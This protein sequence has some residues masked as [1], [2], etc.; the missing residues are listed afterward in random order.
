MTRECPPS[1]I[2]RGGL[3]LADPGLLYVLWRQISLTAR[4]VLLRGCILRNTDWIIGAVIYTGRETKIQMNS[5]DT[6]FKIGSLRAFTDRMSFL[7]FLLQVTCCMIG[8]IVGSIYVASP[9]G[10]NMWY[11]WRGTDAV[12]PDP[13][14]S[15][16][17]QF[18]TY[19]I[20]FTNFIPISLL[21][22][23]DMVKFFQANMMMLDLKMYHETKDNDGSIVEIPMQVRHPA[24]HSL[25]HCLPAITSTKTSHVTLAD[26]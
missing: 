21:V 25:T 2:V 26:R 4:N 12:L 20:I 17:L 19:I 8:G 5:A 24:T 22:T 3:R 10:R 1:F 13:G 7:V 9:T 14:Y 6:P 23:L 16:F 11:L 15:G 18:W